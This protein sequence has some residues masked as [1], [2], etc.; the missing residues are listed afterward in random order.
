M[1]RMDLLIST[2]AAGT[3]AAVERAIPGELRGDAFIV[4]PGETVLDVPYDAWL[5]RVGETVDP[6][7]LLAPT[8]SP[9]QAEPSEREQGFWTTPLGPRKGSAFC[10]IVSGLWFVRYAPIDPGTPLATAWHIVVYVTCAYLALTR[11]VE[12]SLP[13]WVSYVLLAA[14]AVL[15]GITLIG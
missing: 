8:P 6:R 13:E 1:E 2:N 11:I 3:R 9:E 5:P 4:R 7:E 12:V 10:L 14:A 15:T